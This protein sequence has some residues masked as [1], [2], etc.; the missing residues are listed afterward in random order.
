MLGGKLFNSFIIF[1]EFNVSFACN[2]AKTGK[3]FNLVFLEK[4]FNT[5]RVFKRDIPAAFDDL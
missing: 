4:I 5:F 1:S 3:M 2:N